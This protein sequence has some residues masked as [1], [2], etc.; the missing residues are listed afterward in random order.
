LVSCDGGKEGLCSILVGKVEANKTQKQEEGRKQSSDEIS[1]QV[2]LAKEAE[3]VA[4]TTDK[5]DKGKNVQKVIHTWHFLYTTSARSL[6][7]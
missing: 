3:A 1:N 7:F 5:S 6:T 4:T 2:A